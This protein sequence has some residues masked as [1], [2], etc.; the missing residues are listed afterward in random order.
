MNARRNS[1]RNFQILYTPSLQ[2]AQWLKFYLC[3][4]DTSVK[5]D[6][7]FVRGLCKETLDM[8]LYVNPGR[9]SQARVA[10]AHHIQSRTIFR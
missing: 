1:L 2:G 6:Y 4:V 8:Y 9:A 7:V 3:G 5:M 10:M